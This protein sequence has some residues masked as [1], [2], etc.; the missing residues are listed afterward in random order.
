MPENVPENA[1]GGRAVSSLVGSDVRAV[2]G[3]PITS[4]G[5]VN[6]S[7]DTHRV[8]AYGPDHHR[9][10]G[11]QDPGRGHR[12]HRHADRR[13]HPGRGRPAGRSV[14]PGAGGAGRRDH[15]DRRSP[16]LGE[17]V[18]A[19]D[20]VP[21]MWFLSSEDTLVQ[22]AGMRVRTEPE[23]VH[24]LTVQDLHTHHV[25]AGDAPV[26]VHNCS[27]APTDHYLPMPDAAQAFGLRLS[28]LRLS[29]GHGGFDIS[30]RR[31][32]FASR[33]WSRG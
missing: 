12:P 21:G 17:W 20:L 24:N 6:A 32:A 7:Y 13:P 9:G 1:Y 23:R 28:R 3:S 8:A 14:A 4:S 5:R 15:R 19:A 31:D 11:C 16:L 22:V 33:S 18:D 27:V 10:R 26:L 2:R 29:R 30:R 25:R